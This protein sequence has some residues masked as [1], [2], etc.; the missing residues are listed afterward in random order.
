MWDKGNAFSPSLSPFFPNLGTPGQALGA[1]C[2]GTRAERVSLGR[3][4]WGSLPQSSI[5]NAAAEAAGRSDGS[6]W[7]WPGQSC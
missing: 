1:V 4:W 2:S 6:R 7:G 5:L 3:G